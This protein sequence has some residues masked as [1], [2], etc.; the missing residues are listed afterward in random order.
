MALVRL[1]SLAMLDGDHA[2]AREALERAIAIDARTPRGHERLGLLA[3]A[4]NRPQDALRE[5]RRGR[6][7]TGWFRGYDLRTGQ[8]WQM[9]GDRRRAL[10]AYR[11]EAARDPGNQE[12]RDSV[13]AMVHASVSSTPGAP[14]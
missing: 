9:L 6:R 12:A 3:L 14:P 11:R 5:F 7:L 13:Q 2:Q 10:G 8:A 4:Q 1:G